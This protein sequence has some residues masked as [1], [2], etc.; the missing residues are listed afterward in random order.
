M[1][2]MLVQIVFGSTNCYSI[3]FSYIRICL[4]FHGECFKNELHTSDR[5]KKG[6]HPQPWQPA[7]AIYGGHSIQTN[8][9]NKADKQLRKC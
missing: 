8:S 6:L 3:G 4:V 7:A 1:L 5:M 9:C 2:S